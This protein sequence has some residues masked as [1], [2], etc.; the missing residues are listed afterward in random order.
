MISLP[1]QVRALFVDCTR[2]CGPRM[3]FRIHRVSGG[4]PVLPSHNF[5]TS[6]NIF[7]LH[8]IFLWVSFMHFSGRLPLHAVDLLV[9]SSLFL[10]FLNRT[11]FM[12]LTVYKHFR[13]WTSRSAFTLFSTF[14]L[15]TPKETTIEITLD[16]FEL[17]H[18]WF[19]FGGFSQFS[20]YL[21]WKSTKVVEAV[22]QGLRVPGPDIF[23]LVS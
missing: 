4:S 15:V 23:L 18:A 14:F 3:D 1:F 21:C 5:F 16:P 17:V 7:L 6:S 12:T 10:Y 13:V 11:F 2:V 9:S 22:V 8:V 20:N 19:C